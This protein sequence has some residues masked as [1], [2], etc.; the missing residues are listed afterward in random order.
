MNEECLQYF[1]R[2]SEYI[3]RELDDA[4]C[5]KIDAH[6]KECPECRECL[7]SLRKTIELCRQA[8]EEA[9]PEGFRKRLRAV[10]KECFAAQPT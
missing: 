4:I 5:R 9:V 6:L 3:D 7:D 8:S 2:I 10:L 1:H